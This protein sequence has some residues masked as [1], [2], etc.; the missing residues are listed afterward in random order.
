MKKAVVR[1]CSDDPNCC[2]EIV[3]VDTKKIYPLYAQNHEEKE[4]W[5]KVNFTNS[6][7]IFYYNHYYFNC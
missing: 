5:K 1:D 7:I 4:E 6:V 3:R 2:F